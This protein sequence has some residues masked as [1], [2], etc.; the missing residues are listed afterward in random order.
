[1]YIYIIPCV[2]MGISSHFSVY[3]MYLLYEYIFIL[4]T[5]CFYKHYFSELYLATVRSVHAKNF[6]VF[7]H[8]WTYVVFNVHETSRTH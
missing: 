1:M 6:I 3:I 5:F 4:F 8:C 7:K 2:F